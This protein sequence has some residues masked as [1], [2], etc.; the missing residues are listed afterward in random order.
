M[1]WAGRPRAALVLGSVVAAFTASACFGGPPPPPPPPAPVACQSAGPANTSD[2]ANEPA[3]PP[4]DQPISREEAGAQAREVVSTTEVRTKRGEIPLLTVEER[5][6]RP[7]ITSTPV[8]SPDHAASVAEAKAADGDLIGVDVDKPVHATATNDPRFGEQ[9]SFTKVPFEGAWTADSTQGGG[10]TVAV[11]DT[12]VMADHPDLSGQ[13][14]TGA[15]FLHSDDGEPVDPAIGGTEDGSG[16]GTHVAGTI[17][18]KSNNSTGISGAAPGAQIL[19][20]KVL[21]ADG[22]GFTSDVADGITWAVDAGADVINL[23][24]GGGTDAGEQAA[25]EYAR[26]H[27][28]VVAAAGGNDGQ[29]DNHASYPAAY[30]GPQFPNVIAVAATDNANGHPAYGTT[31]SYLDLAAP[32]GVSVSGCASNSAVEILSTWNDGGYC[33]IAGTSMATPHVSAAAA[34]L[35]AANSACT[36]AQVKSRLKAT[37]GDLGTPGPDGTF[38]A[39]I[40]NPLVAGTICP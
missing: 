14:L 7:E 39:G 1:R 2:G 40:V 34:L 4:S 38:G 23:S 25:I 31:G 6:G 24:L 17:A 12:G 16:H 9:W 33:T 8:V 27:N 36:A 29:T 18:A 13:V 35:R 3:R 11:V 32:G 37:A 28:V 10:V 19:P 30:S 15:H 5:G 26:D 21:C 22:G 20:V